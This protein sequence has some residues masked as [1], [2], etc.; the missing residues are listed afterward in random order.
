M[1]ADR[2]PSWGLP[3][4]GSRGKSIQRDAPAVSS[5]Q[6]Q[7]LTQ[8]SPSFHPKKA[9]QGPWTSLLGPC[10]QLVC[11]PRQEWAAGPSG[12]AR[13]LGWTDTTICHIE[14]LSPHDS[15]QGQAPIK[16]GPPGS[17]SQCR[18]HRVSIR[19][20]RLPC[21]RSRGSQLQGL[22]R[23]GGSASGP[24]TPCLPGRSSS[25]PGPCPVVSP[26]DLE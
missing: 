7:P 2:A 22:D 18:A 26:T 25:V 16:G 9:H 5:S 15:P 23:L 3:A 24:W 11:P 20:D 12:L 19:V 6:P 1:G 4:L 17:L 14:C 8:A 21:L 10:C 13:G